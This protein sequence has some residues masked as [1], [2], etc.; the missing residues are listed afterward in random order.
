MSIRLRRLYADFQLLSNLFRDNPFIEI[1]EYSGNPPERYTLSYRVS[2]LVEKDRNISA[3]DLHLVEIVLP[4]DYPREAPFC[5]MLSPVFHPNI[6]PQNICI[7]DYWAAGESLSHLMIRIAEMLTFQSYNL[8][9]PLNGEA[10]RWAEMHAVKLPLDTTD[11][12]SHFADRENEV[13]MQ[14]LKAPGAMQTPEFSKKHL[15]PRSAAGIQEAPAPKAL[16]QALCADCGGRCAA[17]HV[18]C[19]DCYSKRT[20][21]AQHLSTTKNSCSNCGAEVWNTSSVICSY[22]HRVCGDCALRCIGCG[23]YYCAIDGKDK[24]TFVQKGIIC[25]ACQR[26]AAT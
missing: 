3:K 8:K 23:K 24:F 19:N 20:V 10:A 14:I 5:R 21:G 6:S 15:S 1:E 4:R 17:G 22:G 11:F 16:Q 9:S 26:K 12:Y 2:G 18:Y 13:M 25:I 7:G